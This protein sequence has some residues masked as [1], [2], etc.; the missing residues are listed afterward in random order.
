MFNP[1]LTFFVVLFT[2][3]HCQESQGFFVEVA[4]IKQRGYISCTYFF[5]CDEWTDSGWIVKK[6]SSESPDCYDD[7]KHQEKPNNNTETYDDG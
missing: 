1:A 2:M 7:E 6:D 5:A 3:L 4:I